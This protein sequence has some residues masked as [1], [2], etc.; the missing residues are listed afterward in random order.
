MLLILNSR[1]VMQG[2]SLEPA[3]T[4][5]LNKGCDS[6]LCI[7]SICCPSVAPVKPFP[8]KG[9]VS[10]VHK[11][12]PWCLRNVTDAGPRSAPS[13]W[14]CE[15][16]QFLA[17]ARPAEKCL[18]V[19]S[20]SLL[21]RIAQEAPGNS[22][23]QPRIAARESR[24]CAATSCRSG[25]VED[26]SGMVQG[27]RGCSGQPADI[28]VQWERCT[29]EAAPA[30]QVD[31]GPYCEWWSRRKF[32]EHK[33]HVRGTDR[34]PECGPRSCWSPNLLKRLLACLAIENCLA[35]PVNFL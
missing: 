16:L 6:C 22:A 3:V 34:V 18:M 15:P 23:G 17:L 26:V 28:W 30:L 35:C 14:K 19:V 10:R 21:Y 7:W 32:P 4:C 24:G 29:W 12:W 31:K 33:R 20:P 27:A 1:T 8:A 5:C 25:R 2:M 13:L 11:D 9:K